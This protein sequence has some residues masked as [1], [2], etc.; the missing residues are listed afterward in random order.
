[1]GHNVC[2]TGLARVTSDCMVPYKNRET[3]HVRNALLLL[4]SQFATPSL[5]L[6]SHDI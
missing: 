3:F 2:A 4:M 6:S 1:M 5:M